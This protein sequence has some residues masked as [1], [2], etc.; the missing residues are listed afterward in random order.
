MLCPVVH[1]ITAVKVMVNLKNLFRPKDSLGPC[2]EDANITQHKPFHGAFKQQIHHLYSADG[3]YNSEGGGKGPSQ[4][5][6]E[7]RRGNT[8]CKEQ[9]NKKPI[10]L[11]HCEQ[12]AILR[13]PTIRSAVHCQYN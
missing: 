13:F 12:Q 11:I 5:A 4:S 1:I 9:E 2:L 3:G 6:T 8:S 7:H 10:T